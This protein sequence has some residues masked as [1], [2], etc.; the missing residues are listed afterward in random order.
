VSWHAWVLLAWPPA[1][2][3]GLARLGSGPVPTLWQLELGVLRMWHRVAFRPETIGTC[4]ARPV[5]QTWRAR[6]L[7]WRPLRFPFLLWERA[8]APWDMSGL[9]SGRER[10]LRHLLGAY[11]D[12]DQF[13]YDLEM[14][15][16][17]PGAIE[18]LQAR[19]EAIC[20]GWDPRASWLRDLCVY[21]RY[22]EDLRDGVVAYRAGI[23]RSDDP[24]ISFWAYVAWCAAQPVTPAETWRAWRAGQWRLGDGT[25]T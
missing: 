12:A 8:V 6:L 11:H 13:L 23:R 10:V 16:C 3:R 19:L 15:D 25:Q 9:V 24:D 18:E 1:V 7:R 4:S 5:R 20:E 22:H 21:E 17:H 2:A 14:L